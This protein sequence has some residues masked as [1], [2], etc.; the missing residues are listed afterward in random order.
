M[1]DTHCDGWTRATLEIIWAVSDI[2]TLQAL[3]KIEAIPAEL[4]SFWQ[5]WCAGRALPAKGDVDAL[6]IGPRLLPHLYL[7][8]AVEG[9][10]RFRFRVVGSVGVAAAGRELTGKFVDEANPNPDYALYIAGLYR[11]VIEMRRPV[12]SETRFLRSTD[13]VQRWSQ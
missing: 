8:E 2:A 11:H 3:H 5:N 6:E 7:V 1:Q 4:L 12:I 13:R 9:G 10:Q